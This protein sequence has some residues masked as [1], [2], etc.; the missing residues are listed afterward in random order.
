MTSG[1][2]LAVAVGIGLLTVFGSVSAAHAQYRAAALLRRAAA[3]IPRRLPQRP[4]ARRRNRR[5]A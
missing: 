5:R 2:R 3:G 1:K 4:H